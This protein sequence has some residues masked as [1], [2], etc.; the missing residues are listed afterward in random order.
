MN[1]DSKIFAYI[2]G[3][4]EEEIYIFEKYSKNYSSI[5][6]LDRNDDSSLNLYNQ[7]NEIVKDSTFIFKQDNEELSYGKEQKQT[8]VE[9]LI[10]LK[11]KIHIKPPK[12]TNEIKETSKKKDDFRKMFKI[13]LL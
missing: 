8:N 1:D 13:S 7:V 4:K 2:K 10:Y 3:L 12:E 11:N 5:I 9:E 6:E